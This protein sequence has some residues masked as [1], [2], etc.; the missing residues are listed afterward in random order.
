MRGDQGQSA[1]R[2]DVTPILPAIMITLASAM[3]AGTATLAAPES[4]KIGVVFAPGLA[5]DEGVR[6]VISAGGL[7]IDVGLFDN[8]VVAWAESAAFQH[9]IQDE[10]AW[11]LIDPQGF[12]GCFRP[13]FENI[14]YSS[15]Q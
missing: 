9:R 5:S 8:I 10:G 12:G 6:R 1:H 4:G 15:R 7:P 3:L 13:L 2:R 14:Q 11:F